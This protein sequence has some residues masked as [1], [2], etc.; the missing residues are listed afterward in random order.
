MFL[1]ANFNGVDKRYNEFVSGEYKR[2]DENLTVPN[3]G[4]RYVRLK[5]WDELGR[6]DNVDDYPEMITP[7]V[8]LLLR[9]PNGVAYDYVS[10]PDNWQW[11]LWNWWDYNS[12]YR[13][14]RGR[15]EGFY[16]RPGNERTFA[17]TTPGSLTNVYVDMVEAHRA[18]TEAGSP[19]GG[20]R[21]V[22][23]GRNLEFKKNYQ[24]LFNPTGGATVKVRRVL[25]AYYEVEAL[26]VLKPPPTVEYLAARPWLYFWCTQYGKFTGSTRFPQIKNANEIN[27]LPPA[28]ISAPFMSIGGTV[29]VLQKSCVPLQNGAEYSPYNPKR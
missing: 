7:G 9:D 26:D 25:G 6:G 28:G 23:T 27:A 8:G 11:F 16:T 3:D 4:G 20:F 24:W 2:L 13:L 18:F 5:H 21:D 17:R 29:R 22:V 1:T 12:Q 15:I 10:L 14:P 19:E